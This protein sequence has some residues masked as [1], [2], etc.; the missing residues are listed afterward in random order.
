MGWPRRRLIAA[1]CLG[2]IVTFKIDIA[3]LDRIEK[4][5]VEFK[6]KSQAFSCRL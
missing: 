3:R 4:P 6:P 1:L 2:L 5:I